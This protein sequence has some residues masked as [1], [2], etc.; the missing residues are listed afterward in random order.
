M[1]SRERG[2]KMFGHVSDCFSDPFRVFQTVFP[3]DLN[4]FR[5]QFR[6]GDVPPKPLHQMRLLCQNT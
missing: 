3:I 2:L 6:S 5:G 1:F 4:I